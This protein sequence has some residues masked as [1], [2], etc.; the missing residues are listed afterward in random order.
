MAISAP[1][2]IAEAPQ[3]ESLKGR[4]VFTIQLQFCVKKNTHLEPPCWHCQT[5]EICSCVDFERTCDGPTPHKR[6][7]RT[8]TPLDGSVCGLGQPLPG[9]GA[10]ARRCPTS[11]ENQ[12][13][14]PK[15]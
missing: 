5:T 13:I 1:H 10:R 11:F 12:K 14:L 2:R 6:L 9:Q 15:W 4:C 7:P 8:R 3:P